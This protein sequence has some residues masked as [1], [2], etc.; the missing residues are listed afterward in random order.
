MYRYFIGID[1]SKNELDFALVESKKVLLHLE[2]SND[3][4]GIDQ[5]VKQVKSQYKDFTI[6]NTLFCFEH[7]VRAA[8]R[9]LQQSGPGLAAPKTS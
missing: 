8:P 4:K 3:K 2:G 5:F 9:H 1:V 7:T 6:D